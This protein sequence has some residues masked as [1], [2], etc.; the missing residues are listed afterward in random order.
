MDTLRNEGWIDYN[1]LQ[2]SATKRLSG[3]VSGRVSYAYSRGRGNVAT[4]QAD[5]ANSQILGDLNLANDVGPTNVDRPHV[6]SVAGSYDVPRTRGLKVSGVFQARS[7]VPFTLID[8]TFDLDRN[9]STA[10]EYLPAGTYSGSGQEAIT[11]EN[12]GGRN[13]ARGPG[14]AS[15]DLRA[16]YAFRLSRGRTLNAFVDVF[17]ATNRANFANPSGDQR[18]SATFLNLTSLVNGVARTVQLNVRY[19]F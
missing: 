4:G 9:G 5:T 15:L 13:G 10:N 1:T 3:G 12:A 18:L 11:V 19:G 8:S 2:F 14:Y 16:G 7:G 6:L 17:N